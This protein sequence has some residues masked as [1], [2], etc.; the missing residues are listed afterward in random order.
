MAQLHVEWNSYAIPKEL[1]G[2]AA[3]RWKLEFEDTDAGRAWFRDQYSYAFKVSAD[4]SFSIPE[5]LTGTYRLFVGVGQGYLGSG[6]DSTTSHPGDPQIAQ[7]GM[8]VVVSDTAGDSGS[9][10]DLGRIVLNATH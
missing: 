8:K 4:G 3:E 7:T 6:R 2:N 10:M 5:V 1:T 9:P